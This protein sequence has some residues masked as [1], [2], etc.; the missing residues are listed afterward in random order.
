MVYFLKLFNI[1]KNNIFYKFS[2]PKN[3]IIITYS[4]MKTIFLKY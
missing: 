1:I 4:L 3:I 2:G